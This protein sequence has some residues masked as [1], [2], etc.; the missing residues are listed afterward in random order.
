MGM[1][2]FSYLNSSLSLVLFYNEPAKKNY[3]VCTLAAEPPS[4]PHKTN[5]LLAG[6]LLPLSAR[7][8]FMDEPQ[9]VYY[10]YILLRGFLFHVIT[11]DIHFYKSLSLLWVF[12]NRHVVTFFKT[13]FLKEIC[14][15]R[16][17]HDNNSVLIP[18]FQNKVAVYY[19]C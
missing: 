13:G 6:P 17:L 4:S 2:N 1:D 16:Y 7:T 10:W 9:R 19:I 12:F 8:Y 15:V 18:K 3:D 5:T 14:I 11:G